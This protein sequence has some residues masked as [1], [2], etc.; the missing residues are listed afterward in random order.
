MP[1]QVHWSEG[2]FLQP[3]HLQRAARAT[4]EQLRCERRLSWPFPWGV[5]ELRL[6]RD[7]LDNFQLR[8]DRLRAIMPSGLEINFPEDT[9]LPVIDLRQHLPRGGSVLNVR[10][11]VP[12]WQPVRGNSP[13]VGRP[14]DASSKFLYAVS[15]H[16]VTD[17]N[18]GENP[19][20]V[21]FRKSNARL[22]VAGEDTSDLEVIPLLKVERSGGAD[23]AG[24]PRADAE[25]V[26][27]CLVLGGSPVLR[28]L[29]RDLA[30][31]VEASRKE[32]VNRLAGAAFEIGQVQL[33]HLE[34]LLRLRTLNR[35]AARLPSLAN[36]ANLAPFT[37]YL[38]LRELLGELTALYPSRDAFEVP[39]Y[40]HENLYG[41]FYDLGVRIREFL[42][43]TL[44]AT[45]EKAPFLEEADSRPVCR[46]NDGHF[47]RPNAWLLGIQ[48]RLDPQA[49]AA[50]VID[51]DRFKLMPLSL[52]DRA[53]RG[54]ELKWE[55]VPPPGLPTPS[56]LSYFRLQ[57]TTSART[58][59]VGKQDLALTIR[60]RTQELDWTGSQFTL[61]MMLPSG[62]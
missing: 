33:A 18:S 2:L 17:E 32:L 47:T 48:T 29:V 45:Y 56:G 23:D 61:Y 21:Q 25:Y 15:E 30:A 52:G 1:M 60:W 22:L 50:Y 41:S 35:F 27:P 31:Q 40:D 4:A 5:V 51:P 46:L 44:V 49:L 19:L 28:E 10:L 24:L 14:A 9:D 36:L 58:W 11:A 12:V 57:H 20:T 38:E 55:P 39:E 42:R 34:P 53:I 13:A 37:Y 26:P 54:I 8:F 43:G 62:K 3:H 59:M 7:E 6:S 16:D